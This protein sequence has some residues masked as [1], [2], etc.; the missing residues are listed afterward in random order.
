MKDWAIRVRAMRWNW[1]R[2]LLGVKGLTTGISI[3]WMGYPP[4]AHGMQKHQP[5]RQPIGVRH[6][7]RG[8]MHGSSSVF[9]FRPVI[10]DVTGTSRVSMR[11]SLRTTRAV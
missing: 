4:P 5:E 1:A 7:L 8:N 6:V 3:H 11:P 10:R 9:A 2:K